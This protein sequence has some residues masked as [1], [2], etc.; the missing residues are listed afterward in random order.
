MVLARTY[1]TLIWE[2]GRQVQR[3]RNHLRE[4]FPAA[5]AADDTLE[6]LGKTP[7][8]ARARARGIEHNHGLRRL[9]NRLVGILYGCLKSRIL[10]D[11][12]TA[13][14]HEETSLNLQSQLDASSKTSL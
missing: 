4:Y 12:T 2:Q 9:A 7:D 3:L 8:P 13:W 6:L 5:L 11:E 14:P 1:K 10:Y